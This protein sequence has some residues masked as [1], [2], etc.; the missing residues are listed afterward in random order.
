VFLYSLALNV[1]EE[2]MGSVSIRYTT[3]PARCTQARRSLR[4]VQKTSQAR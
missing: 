2:D 3:S 4:T 1:T